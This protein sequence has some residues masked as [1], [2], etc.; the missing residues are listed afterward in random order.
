MKDFATRLARLQHRRRALQGELSRTRIELA[1]TQVRF[2]ILRHERE[3]ARHESAR[4]SA[5]LE[6][7]RRSRLFRF[8]SFLRRLPILSRWLRPNPDVAA[9][10]SDTVKVDALVDKKRA[11]TELARVALQG[12]LSTDRRLAFP[13]IDCPRVSIVLVLFNRAELTFGCLQ[14]ILANTTTPFELIV[15]DNASVDDT[16]ALLDQLDGVQIVRNADN[17]GFPAAVNQGAR[18]ARGDYLLLLNNDTQLLGPAIDTAVQVL[19]E[20]ADAGAV[21]G[22]VLLLDGT[23]QE[24]GGILW[25]EAYTTFHGRG[26]GPDDA[27]FQIERNVDYCSGA[28]LMVR[29]HLFNQVGMLD[30]AYSP[31]YYEDVQLCVRLWQRGSRVVYHP[32]IAILHYEN[33]SSGQTGPH[34]LVERNQQIFLEKNQRWLVDQP[35]F[36]RVSPHLASLSKD[37]RPRVLV[38]VGE[39]KATP[40]D[41]VQAL[42]DLN[43]YV[44]V[45][46]PPGDDA[47]PSPGV[48]WF[49]PADQQELAAW[50]EERV[51]FYV[52]VLTVGD[53]ASLRADAVW[54]CVTQFVDIAEVSGPL[55]TWLQEEVNKACKRSLRAA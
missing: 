29:R 31:G 46:M 49:S 21:G 44:T 6:S 54:R 30:E 50:L 11:A 47:G 33:A 41:I 24:A 39:G 52:L 4:L 20:Q 5:E 42:L 3:V 8:C 23:L 28:F 17:R 16:S 43:C 19:G 34:A 27:E 2:D 38:A 53:I 48:D 51:G 1:R 32:H 36:R 40:R 15:V 25:Q 26:R 22:K 55:D 9:P 13:E 18:L 35:S 45:L 10:P 12:F 37:T 7:L 14:S